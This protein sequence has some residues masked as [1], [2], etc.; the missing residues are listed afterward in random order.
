MILRNDGHVIWS[1]PAPATAAAV[2]PVPN[3][4]SKQPTPR[5]PGGPVATID[6]TRYGTDHRIAYS[7]TSR[8]LLISNPENHVPND[9]SHPPDLRV[10]IESPQM[11][12]AIESST[13]FAEYNRAYAVLFALQPGASDHLSITFKATDHAPGKVKRTGKHQKTICLGDEADMYGYPLPP[14]LEGL[15][16][17]T[18]RARASNLCFLLGQIGEAEKVYP[19]TKYAYETL[20]FKSP[21]DVTS[22]NAE[23]LDNDIQRLIKLTPSHDK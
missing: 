10:R 8:I 22:T 3:S 19:R 5:K 4:A 13:F 6:F 20:G 16:Y 2:S 18:S 14:T 9:S 17:L 12:A 7:G 15:D 21:P 23:S 1:A 11:R